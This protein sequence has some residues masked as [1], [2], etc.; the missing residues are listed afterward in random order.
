MKGRKTRRAGITDLGGGWYRIR[1]RATDPRTGRRVEK[2]REVQCRSVKEA[3][4][5]SV[6]LRAEMEQ[7]AIGSAPQRLRLS[8]HAAAWLRRKT[9]TKRPDGSRRLSP[10]TRVRYANAIEHH[11]VPALGEHFVD[12]ITARDVEDWRDYLAERM[13]ATTVNGLLNVLR[14]VLRDVGNEVGARVKALDAD[15]TRITGD[16]PNALREQELQAFLEVARND[17]KQ[18]YAMFLVLFTTA[19]RYRSGNCDPRRGSPHVE[20]PPRR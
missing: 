8:D 12:G 7:E 9:E 10:T 2:D 15:D 17:W 5:L 20:S 19:T 3:E 4:K 6:T 14:S 13:A 18:H 1:V 11:I 16:E